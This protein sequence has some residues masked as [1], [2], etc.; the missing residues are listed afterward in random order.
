MWGEG[1]GSRGLDLGFK[2][3]GEEFSS[4]GSAFGVQG[5]SLGFGLRVQS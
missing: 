3:W 4:G 1:V 5:L 2:V